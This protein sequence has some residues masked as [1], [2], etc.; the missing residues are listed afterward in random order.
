V[1]LDSI[2]A[3]TTRDCKNFQHDMNIEIITDE[4]VSEK[5][6]LAYC[7]NGMSQPQL[8]VFSQKRTKYVTTQASFVVL[9]TV[10]LAVGYA[11]SVSSKFL[12]TLQPV[13]INA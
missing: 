11:Q 6:R 7:P 3:N 8:Q 9:L 10:M 5:K 12:T 1:G 2:S 13:F 4:T